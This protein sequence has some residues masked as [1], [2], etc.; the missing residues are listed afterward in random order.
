MSNNTTFAVP[1]DKQDVTVHLDAAAA[2]SGS[3]F[4]ESAPGAHTKH[5]K[6]VAF[7]EDET[8]FFPLTPKEGGTTEFIRKRNIRMVEA[9]YGEDEGL[10]TA[11]S[12]MQRVSITAIFTD[13][14]SIN[15]TLMADVPAERGDSP[16]VS[17]FPI[18]SWLSKS[19]TISAT[20]TSTRSGKSYTPGRRNSL[21]HSSA[22]AP[23][24][25]ALFPP[26]Q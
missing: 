18:I 3:I 1:K 13:D 24:H 17:I 21:D 14:S 4:L 23:V 11:L 20:S 19:A 9:N 5:H 6:V 15:G 22:R 2:V 16:T 26:N 8:M 12:L 25:R 7:L 10:K